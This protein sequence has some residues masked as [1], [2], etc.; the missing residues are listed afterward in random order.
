[1]ETKALYAGSFDPITIGHLDLIKRAS[2][3]HKELVV[4]IIRNPNKSAMLLPEERKQL[5]E[6]A[7]APLK[8]VSVDIFEGLLA[9]YVNSHGFNVVIR[10]LRT[11]SDFDSEIQMAQMNASLFSDNVEIVFLMTD[12]KFS[13]VSSS[14]IKEVH[15]LSGDVGDLV[16][17][18]V[19]EYLDNKKKENKKKQ[20]GK[21]ETAE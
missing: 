10:G 1:M 7:V 16:P 11:T 12:P 19:L 17:K 5:I 6:K 3:L 4:G 2:K 18:C 15:D 21:N 14:M 13:F 8:N 20:G 9:D